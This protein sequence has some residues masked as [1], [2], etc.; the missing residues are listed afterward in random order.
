MHNKITTVEP[1]TRDTPEISTP[2]IL[3]INQ[4]TI[5][6]PNYMETCTLTWDPYLY[7]VVRF[8]VTC[9]KYENVVCVGVVGRCG[10]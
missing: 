10:W 6:G 1:L 3:K 8:S 5:Y 9:T 4:D 2:L 7:L